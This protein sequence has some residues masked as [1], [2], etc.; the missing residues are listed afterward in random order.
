METTT[1]IV[2]HKDGTKEKKTWSAKES[3]G[4]QAKPS[5]RLKTPNK[6]KK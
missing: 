6:R 3:L 1:Y 2:T 5:R 4:D